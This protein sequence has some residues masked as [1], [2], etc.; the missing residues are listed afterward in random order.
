MATTGALGGDAAGHRRPRR[1]PAAEHRPA[2]APHRD[3]ARPAGA[4]GVGV[5]G[6]GH[7]QGRAS[8]HLDAAAIAAMDPED[9]RRGLLRQA[10]AAP[11]P[12][13]RWP[14]G[15][16]R[17]ARSSPSTTAATPAASGRASTSGTSS[18]PGCGS[19]PATAR[20]SPR[21]SWPSWPSAWAW[22]RGLGGGGRQVRRRHPRSVADID[23][24]ESLAKVRE[25]KKAQK[26]AKQGQAGPPPQ[27]LT[28]GASA[29]RP[30]GGDKSAAP[31]VRGRSGRTQCGEVGHERSR[32]RIGPCGAPPFDRVIKNRRFLPSPRASTGVPQG[33]RHLPAV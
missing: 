9:A 23:S 22:R 5:H 6:P 1:R 14:A 20:R 16:T 27:T 8:A 13:R 25:W 19:C 31:S 29:C 4:D 32:F 12:G 28:A 26:A 21:S 7:P 33:S 3:A 11:L 30:S 17:C 2:G 10:R 18:S 15:P 24:P